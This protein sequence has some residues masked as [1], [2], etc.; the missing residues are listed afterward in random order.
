MTDEEIET[1]AK[2]YT[3]TVVETVEDGFIDAITEYLFV[4]FAR[5]IEAKV[6]AEMAPKFKVGDKVRIAGSECA[7]KIDETVESPG[8]RIS[9]LW[10]IWKQDELEAVED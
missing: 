5:D 1:I 8:Y 10:R 9:G 3:S 7:F 4:D 2:E 6:R